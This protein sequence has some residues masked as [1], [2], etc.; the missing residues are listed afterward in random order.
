M[1]DNDS[2]NSFAALKQ[3]IEEKGLDKLS[4]AEL[5]S[6]SDED[7]EAKIEKLEKDLNEYQ[8]K[9]ADLSDEEK[10]QDDGES[11]KTMLNNLQADLEEQKKAAPAPAEGEAAPAEGEAAPAEG[12]AA[13]AEGEAA[14]TTTEETEGE[15][16]P[17][18]GQAAAGP[19]EGEA[20]PTTE[21]T[22][23]EDA[24]AGGEDAAGAG[25]PEGEPVTAEIDAR[26]IDGFADVTFEVTDGGKLKVTATPA[27]TGGKSRKMKKMK[28]MQS[29]KK[30][31]K[32]TKRG[33]KKAVKQSRKKK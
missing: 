6:S 2:V 24:A 1:S 27:Q 3:E 15:A 20:A 28:K 5:F 21:E 11:V 9:Y 12:E 31:P 30:R 19:A 16:G 33:G 4:L 7:S 22:E 14:P 26:D 10:S 29:K 13:P 18:E 32:Q 17:A 23:G 25:Q 8:K